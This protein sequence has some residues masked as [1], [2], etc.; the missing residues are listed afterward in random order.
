MNAL[1][2]RSACLATSTL[3][4]PLALAGEGFDLGAWARPHGM[5]DGGTACMGCRLGLGT[6]D[7]GDTSAD[8]SLF[9][10]PATG[11]SMLNY[12]P[13]RVVDF[14]RMKLDI[15]I[16]DMN[17]PTLDATQ[18]L[19]F[20][21]IAEDLAD[22]TLDAKRLLIKS[23]STPG[24][25][26]TFTH[27][28]L[29]MTLA[30]DPPL[31]AGKP[32]ELT[33]DYAMTSP[34]EG[35][36]WTPESDSWPG[37]A[38]QLHTQGEP[39][40]NS[41]WFPCHDFPNDKLT[42]EL[43]VTVPRGYQVSSNGR[44]LGRSNL[45]KPVSD[46]LGKTS[47]A[48][49]ETWKWAQDEQ[50]GGPHTNYLVSLIVGKF[51]V[52]DV[53]G[54]KAPAPSST[55][56]PRSNS[57]PSVLEP[58]LGRS[59][60]KPGFKIEMPV[61][62]PQGRGGDVV[63][64]YGRTAEMVRFF[65]ALFDEPFPWSKYAQLVVHNFAFGGMENTSA[66]TMF[67]TAILSRDA[68]IDHDL[69]GLISHELAHQWF[70]DLITCNSWEHVWLNEGFATYLTGL[71][72]E[73][74]DGEE[75][76]QTS[77]LGNFD[78]VIGADRGKAPQTPGMVS[79]AYRNPVES[80]RRSSNPY[81]K[82]ASILHML[83][84][85]LGDE[86][87]FAGVREYLNRYG[88]KTAET[89]DLR[90]T[91]EDV[92]GES[93]QQF[94]TQWTGRPGIPRLKVS[95]SFADGKLSLAVS[96]T[97]PVDGYNPAFVFDLPVSVRTVSGVVLTRVIS[98]DSREESLAIDLPSPPVWVAVNP[99][100]H[101]LADISLDQPA[102]WLVNQA[103]SGPT[104][105]ARIYAVRTLAQIK[106]D[107][108]QATLGKLAMSTRETRQL[109]TECL[110]ALEAFASVDEAMKLSESSQPDA[111]LR[112]QALDSLASVAG[113]AEA[114]AAV[115]DRAIARFREAITDP[116][117]RARASALR[118]L[119][120]LKS[121]LPAVL[122]MGTRDLANDSQHDVIRQTVA[123]SL[124]GL[125]SPEAFQTALEISRPGTNSFT[126]AKSIA[127]IAKLSRHSPDVALASL[128]NY[129][130]D[131]EIRARRA[132]IAGLGEIG[133][134]EAIAMLKARLPGITSPYE[135]AD[136]ARIV[137]EAEGKLSETAR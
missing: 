136:V 67:D 76:Y 52:V 3:L 78:G 30:F 95:S 110:R 115:R 15:R 93:L 112:I 63:Q 44:L 124:P 33:I 73:H 57:T 116:A 62:V 24:S 120:T 111:Y 60:T 105:A 34:P 69:D 72:F 117:V 82:G 86:V 81:A 27:D 100:L 20:T 51:D 32:A 80:L 129:L 25:K 130:A 108:A 88:H 66:T 65:S 99:D 4:A 13:H 14:A 18:V 64:T 6:L 47:L 26:A 8:R 48:P 118:G 132:A 58:L 29:R 91:L 2:L 119:A 61:Y 17:V 12:P 90:T 102:E 133:T 131:P 5:E 74:R 134:P 31:P 137:R 28:G 97:Q 87:F 46:G 11:R 36:F 16:A 22:L 40:T 85:K 77:V 53:A 38:A 135:A 94:F 43:S 68:L 83:R 41:F 23:V 128:A 103:A 96:Q 7:A 37:R 75:A 1:I 21:P 89:D 39:E 79:K 107:Q 106:P 56:L 42:T 109:R 19:R 35:L 84:R 49:F 104:L 50:A 122:A 127:A 126:R 92:S 71:W 59:F 101:T 114:P 125:D 54:A 55:G 45:I 123:D 113:R 98:V 121:D 9:V 10:D 70:G